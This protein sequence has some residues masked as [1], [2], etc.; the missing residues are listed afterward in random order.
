VKRRLVK[1][2]L[3]VTWPG[4]TAIT[5]DWHA[6]EEVMLAFNYYEW[7]LGVPATVEY[8]TVSLPPLQESIP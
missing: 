4:G 5:S 6:V 1:A 8:M 7:R 2:R 3:T